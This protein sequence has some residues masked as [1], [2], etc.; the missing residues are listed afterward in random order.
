MNEID[1]IILNLL[2]GETN[3]AELSRLEEWVNQSPENDQVLQKII[4]YYKDHSGGE[5]SDRVWNRVREKE[6]A[7]PELI[8]SDHSGEPRSFFR[9][10]RFQLVAVFVL[11]FSAISFWGFSYLFPSKIIEKTAF[12]EKKEILLPDQTRII[13]NA[14]SRISYSKDFSR[15]VWLEGEAFFSVAPRY[16]TQERFWVHTKDLSIKVLGTSFNVHHFHEKTEVYLEEGKIELNLQGKSERDTMGNL[17]MNPGELLVYAK[18]GSVFDKKSALSQ[19]HTSWKDGAAI[20]INTPLR[21]IL[22]KMEEIYGVKINIKD[23]EIL[24]HEYTIAVPIE[25]LEIA[26]E[27]LENILNIKVDIKKDNEFFV[28]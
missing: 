28:E 22:I 26:I 24:N 19:A 16:E 3:Q 4:D 15:E 20:M 21:E 5:I 1:H 17:V 6:E 25:N 7:R 8:S 13:L 27:A 12:G 9:Q 14:N 10:F 2:N 23:Q 11:L 18:D